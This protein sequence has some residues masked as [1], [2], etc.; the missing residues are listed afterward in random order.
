MFLEDKFSAETNYGPQAQRQA[1]RRQ[2]RAGRRRDAAVQLLGAQIGGALIF[3][4]GARLVSRTGPALFAD[5]LNVGERVILNARYTGRDPEGCVRLFGADFG[6][7][8]NLGGCRIVNHDGPILNLESASVRHLVLPPSILCSEPVS[9]TCTGKTVRFDN[10]TYERVKS[11]AGLEPIVYAR[12]WI[13]WLRKHHIPDYSAQPY[14]QV[15]AVQHSAGNNAAARD[16]LINQ[17]EHLRNSDNIGNWFSRGGNWIFGAFA[18]YGYKVQKTAGWLAGVVVVAA[19]LGFFAP[20]HVDT[21]NK[22]C[23]RMGRLELG[24]NQALPAISIGTGCQLSSG[25]VC[26]T[27]FSIA[28]LILRIFSL[29]LFVTVVASLRNLVRKVH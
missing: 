10:L 14:R 13:H 29:I 27:L 6:H 19:V 9:R 15:A 16:I 25:G 23:T 7:E 3:G 18:G 24:L 26:S 20:S 17:Q 8:L 4:R 28:F 11:G 5:Y 2:R 1:R 21:G 22:A 12:H